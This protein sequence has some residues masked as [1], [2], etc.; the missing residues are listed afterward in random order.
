METIGILG[1]GLIGRS[2]AMLFAAAG[3]QVRLYDI[4]PKQVQSALR[5][6][7]SQLVELEKTKLLRGARSAKQQMALI[8]G[9]SSLKDC[10]AGALMVQECTPEI[11]DVKMK[12]LRD[13]D[14]VVQAPTIIASSTSTHMP[15]ILSK[16]LKNKERFIVAHPVNPPYYVRL[17]ELVPAPYTEAWVATKVRAIMEE[18]GQVPVSLKKEVPGFSLNRIQYVILNEVWR[19]VA[20][21]V[22]DVTDVDKVMSEGLGPRYAFLGALETAHLNAEG[23]ESYAERY[24]STIHSVSS[25]MGPVPH[26]QGD[27]LAA[28]SRQLC[29]RIPLDKLQERRQW[30]DAALTKLAVLKREMEA[31][32]KTGLR[33]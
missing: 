29:D 1:S 25:G 8:S 4:E 7:E 27:V 17:V 10:V 5:E 33:K 2:W 26:M 32:P 23:M 16:D 12:A 6:I 13:L 3:Y 19:Q 18:T 24:A 20:D 31:V 22:L 15:S 30:R 21:G 14:A 9:T 11:L 28:V